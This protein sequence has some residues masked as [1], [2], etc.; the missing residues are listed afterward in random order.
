MAESEALAAIQDILQHLEAV[1]FVAH[2]DASQVL[3]VLERFG[4]VETLHWLETARDLFFHDRDAGKAFMRATPDTVAKTDCVRAWTDQA[5]AFTRQVGSWK[6][7]ESFMQQV[8]DVCRDW[9]EAGERKWFEIG[10]RWLARHLDSA[11]VY[12]GT[13]FRDLSGERG[14]AGVSELLGLA[15]TLFAQR[16]LTL[17][18]YLPGALALQRL[19]GIE[20]VAAWARRGAAI[21][22][23][24]RQRGEAY[25]RLESEE[26]LDAVLEALPGFRPQRHGRLL[27]LLLAAWFGQGFSLEP[28]PWRPDHG[29][30]M[31]ET[32]GKRLFLPAVLSDREEAV[33]AVLHG[34]AHLYFDTY[35]QRA[36]EALFAAAGR[37]HPPLDENQRITWRPLFSRYG[38]GMFRFQVVFDLCEDLRIDA[39]LARR[40]PHYLQRLLARAEAGPPP[41]GPAGVYYRYACAG[42]RGALGLAPL[43]ER[44]R[45]LLEES[46]TLVDAF[47]VANRLYADADFPPL[48]L[49]QRAAAYLP[50][51]SLNTA[52]PVYPKRVLDSTP[53]DT[54]HAEQNGIALQ[55]EEKKCAAVKAPRDAQGDPDMN[56]P[57]EETAGSGGRVGVGIPVPATVRGPGVVRAPGREGVPYPEWDYR[58]Q[59]Y[60]DDWAWVQERRLTERDAQRAA[61]LQVQYAGVLKRLRR[62]LQLQR[63]T[64]LAP[65]RRQLDGDELDLEAVVGYVTEKRAGRAPHPRVYRRRHAQ[66]RD[67]AVLLL[68]DLSTSIMANAHNGAGKVVDRLRA[69]VLLFAEALQDVGDPCAVCGFASQHHDNVNFY[70]IKDFNEPINHDTRAIIAALS[71]RLAS[72]LGAA[73]RH[74]VRRFDTVSAQRR[75]LLI[76]SDGR[77][78]D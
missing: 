30:P 44:L 35:E 40:V 31:I 26:S 45:P 10:Q 6:A 77:P 11:V 70:V 52:R 49:D 47:H 54:G 68:A 53:Q 9:G 41:E 36:I 74:A 3:P 64:R 43:D 48:A 66:Q 57:P 34:A 8:G 55:R 51:R 1:S 46:A 33:L 16:R 38:E 65:Q 42:L 62:A 59:R 29:R 24:G 61:E 15:E 67:T 78:A 32:D 37:G 20:G 60:I 72:R 21:M 39:R 23:S 50:G 27:H 76:L 71:G 4:A 12:F 18:L 56:V 75:L 69:G 17:D 5:R 13:P 22:Q 63:P 7:L 28:G 2:R 25:F 19:I 14:A 58:E 73:I